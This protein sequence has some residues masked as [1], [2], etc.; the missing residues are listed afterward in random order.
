MKGLIILSLLLVSCGTSGTSTDTETYCNL[1]VMPVD[2]KRPVVIPTIISTV[3]PTV[4]PT[5]TVQES[6]RKYETIL[7]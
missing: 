5:E 1:T 3:T 4:V 6:P 2:C 7:E